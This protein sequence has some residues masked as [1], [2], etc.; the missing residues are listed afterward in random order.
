[1]CV[2]GGGACAGEEGWVGCVDV[3]VCLC[4]FGGCVCMLCLRW[5]LMLK[6]YYFQ[7]N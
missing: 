7:Y 3:G 4:E 1:M 5:F 2:W 6:K